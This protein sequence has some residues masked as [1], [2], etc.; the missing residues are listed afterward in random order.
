MKIN[1]VFSAESLRR[2]PDDPLPGQANNPPLPVKVT[3]DNEYEVQ[4][5]VAVR[6]VRGKLVYRA[7]WASTDE[8]PEFYPASDFKYSPH[9]LKC[10]HLANP[11]LPGPPANLALWLQAWEDGVDDYDH[12]DSNKP[13]HAR[14][15]TSFFRRGE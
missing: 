15:R 8:D 12:L 11:T 9:L 3:A 2:D 6:L 10:F 13:A 14:S 4:E 5:I 7:K 1:P